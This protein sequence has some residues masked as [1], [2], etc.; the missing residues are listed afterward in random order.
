[1]TSHRLLS[2]IIFGILFCLGIFFNRL[3]LLAP[4]IVCAATAIGTNEFFQIARVRYDK[5]NRSFGVLVA[6]ALV[7]LGYARGLDER[8]PF[9]VV[10]TIAF[11]GSFSLTLVR[12]GI[13]RFM[14][15]SSITFLGCFYVGLPMAMAMEILNAPT[16]EKFG[17]FLIIFLIVT[18]W[19]ADVGAYFVGRKFGRHKLAPTLSPGKSYEGFFGGIGFSVIVA[20]LL[21]LLWP[22]IGQLF[23]WYEVLFLAV[24]FST[25]GVLGD[26]VESAMKREAGVKDSGRNVTGH[27]GMLDIIDSLLFTAPLFYLHLV[28]F[29]KFLHGAGMY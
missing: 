13:T 5:A 28:Y 23:T 12:R 21:K 24:L 14:A 7:I 25:V 4:I 11:L 26:L 9:F 20:G 29:Y 19:S 18:T 27:G 8:F 10:L 1:M 22:Q 17:R 15:Q 16:F 6:V 3:A 2:G